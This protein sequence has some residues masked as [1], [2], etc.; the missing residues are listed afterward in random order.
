MNSSEYN[1][2]TSMAMDNDVPEYQFK[3]FLARYWNN[4]DALEQVVKILS[5]PVD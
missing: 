2:I 3:L 1:R 5:K 4:P